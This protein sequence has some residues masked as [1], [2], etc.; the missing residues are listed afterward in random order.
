MTIIEIL[1]TGIGLAMDAVAVS[2][3]KGLCIKRIVFKDIMIVALYFGFFQF[4]MPIIGYLFGNMFSFFTHSVD[5]IIAFLLLSIIGIGMVKDG[6]NNDNNSMN[7]NTNY[8]EMVPLAIATSID[9]LSVGITFSFLKV[10]MLLSVLMIGIVTF[11]LSM[12]GV[13]VGYYFGLKYR[14]KALMIGGIILIFIG[15]RI[16]IY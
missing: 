16:L 3:C 9:A 12:I 10:N 2:I 15:L 11:I 6:L 14:K 7:N 8:K 4:I 1:L 5:N 13:I